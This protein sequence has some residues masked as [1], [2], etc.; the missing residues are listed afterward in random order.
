MHDVRLGKINFYFL[1]K[2]FEE[3]IKSR[4][5]VL[6]SIVICWIKSIESNRNQ[7]TDRY[8]FIE[9]YYY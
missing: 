5:S 1:L 6:D 3:K 8:F 2:Y 9:Y 4:F 7:T